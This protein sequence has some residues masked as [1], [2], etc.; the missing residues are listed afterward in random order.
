MNT[1]LSPSSLTVMLLAAIIGAGA[2]LVAVAA[3]PSLA[4]AAGLPTA[5]S[6]REFRLVDDNGDVRAILGLGDDGMPVVHLTDKDGKTVATRELFSAPPPSVQ[7]IQKPLS[8][9]LGLDP[10]D[11]LVLEPQVGYAN[12]R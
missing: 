10:K 6:A 8:N 5:L 7:L 2:A 1:R 4:S 12:G 3:I 11:C 9:T